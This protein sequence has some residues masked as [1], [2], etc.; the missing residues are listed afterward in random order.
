MLDAGLMASP[1]GLW[2]QAG[3]EGLRLTAE[4]GQTDR[5][6]VG[7]GGPGLVSS[8]GT[9]ARLSVGAAHSRVGARACQK[10]PPRTEASLHDFSVKHCGSET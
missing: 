8:P 2:W 4:K 3:R 10:G 5:T 6:L 7:Q 9:M 1:E